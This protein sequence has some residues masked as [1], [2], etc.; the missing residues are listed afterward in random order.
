MLSDLIIAENRRERI[1]HNLKR[2]V[3]SP[4]QDAEMQALEKVLACLNDNRPAAAAGLSP[5]EQRHLR[6]FQFLTLKPLMVI[7]NSDEQGFASHADLLAILGESHP[8]IEFAGRFEM[9]LGGL[10][11]DEARLFMDDMHISSSARDRLTV[12]AYEVLGYL[13]FF[14]VGSDEVRAW[15]IRSGAT[16]LDA[17]GA[18]HSDLARGFIRAECFTYEDLKRHGSEK[19]LTQQGLMRLEGRDYRVQDGDILSI[20]FSV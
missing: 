10:D 7:L 13:T 12:L 2:G 5:E 15:T 18:I 4:A 16:A 20:R 9:E 14:T 1:C 17:A 19:A 3:K 11:E 6:G 8:A